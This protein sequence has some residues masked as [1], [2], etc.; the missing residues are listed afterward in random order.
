VKRT[1]LLAAFAGV[2]ACLAAAPAY[3][4]SYTQFPRVEEIAAKAPLAFRGV[5]ESVTSHAVPVPNARSMPYTAT[6]FRV[7]TAFRGTSPGARVTLRHLGGPFPELP[8]RVMVVPGLA[9]FS[10]GD[11]AFVFSNDRQHP[12]F[13]TSFGD[14]GVMRVARA[15][16]G[17][18]VVLTEDWRFLLSTP[19]GFRQDGAACV[20]SSGERTTCTPTATRDSADQESDAEGASGASGRAGGSRVTVE[21]FEVAVRSAVARQGAIPGRPQTISASAAVFEAALGAFA[22]GDQAE[23]DRIFRAEGI[24]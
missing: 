16:G 15:D 22:R 2:M 13:G 14:L 19:V 24:R 7:V 20:P 8:N 12:F 5:V 17:A 18:R 21:S 10:E 3:A 11:E 23:V 4:V 9:R 6:T 1:S